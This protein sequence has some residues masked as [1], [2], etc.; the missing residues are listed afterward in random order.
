MYMNSKPYS[1]NLQSLS[2][3]E[4][5]LLHNILPVVVVYNESEFPLLIFTCYIQTT[6]SNRGKLNTFLPLSQGLL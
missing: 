6:K 2:L 4:N 5:T 1:N 3:I